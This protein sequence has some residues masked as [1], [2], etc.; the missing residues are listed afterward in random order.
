MGGTPFQVGDDYPARLRDLATGL[1]LAARTVFTGH[2]DDVRPALAAMDVFVHAGN[3]E[4]FGLVVVEAMA[5]AKPVVAFT[6]GALPE[7]VVDGETGLLVPPGDE[8][9]LA[10]RVLHLLTHRDEARAM[11]ER[12]RAR[13]EAYFHIVRTVR[14]FEEALT[15][16]ITDTPRTMHNV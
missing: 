8:H 12:G 15:T 14:A 1:G 6:H 5:M 13:V 7:I 2:L 3:P 16:V 9:T 10:A 11:G 4:P